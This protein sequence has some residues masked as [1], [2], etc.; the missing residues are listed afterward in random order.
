MGLYGGSK[1]LLG[2]LCIATNVN[3]YN[4]HLIELTTAG[5]GSNETSE[6]NISIT[7]NKWYT[8]KMEYTNGNAVFKLYD[9]DNLLQ[10]STLSSSVL[11]ASSNQL[12]I[13]CGMYG[14]SQGNIKDI[15]IK[16]L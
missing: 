8:I 15:K 1:G 6:G 5:S 9:G 11:T 7:T 10:T 16:P 13:A 12:M 2:K 14:N 4:A 3:I